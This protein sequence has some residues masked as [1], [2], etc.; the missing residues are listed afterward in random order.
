[1]QFIKTSF[2][3][4][5]TPPPPPAVGFDHRQRS[6]HVACPKRSQALEEPPFL[7]P[8]LSSYHSHVVLESVMSVGVLVPTPPTLHRRSI[9][10]CSSTAPPLLAA[11]ATGMLTTPSGKR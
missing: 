4:S 1:M 9:V 5:L 6:A 7:K 3:L 8:K 2:F 11:I 10:I